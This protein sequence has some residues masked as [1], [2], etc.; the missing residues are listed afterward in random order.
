VLFANVHKKTAYCQ[1]QQAAQVNSIFKL[2][3][4]FAQTYC[5]ENLTLP[6][7]TKI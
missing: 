3:G 6:A 2:H 5:F 4:C 1:K 7:P